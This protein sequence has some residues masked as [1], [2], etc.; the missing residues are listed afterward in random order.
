VGDRAHA[1]ILVE[2]G[3]LLGEHVR[4]AETVANLPSVFTEPE[5]PFIACVF[6]ILRKR[7]TEIAF[8]LG[9]LPY[10]SDGSVLQPG[11]GN[12]PA[13]ILGPGEASQAHY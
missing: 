11:Y 10:F 6:G 2:I 4:V 5:H 7:R 12:C 1:A 3:E 13:I 9:I 8:E